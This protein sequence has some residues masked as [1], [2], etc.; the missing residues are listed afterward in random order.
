MVRKIGWNELAWGGLLVAGIWTSVYGLTAAQI[1]FRSVGWLPGQEK[2]RL[3]PRWY[4]RLFIAS[5]GLFIAI[6]ALCSLIGVHRN[7]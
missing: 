6:S 4:H 3:T 7:R 1:T 5:V 2:E